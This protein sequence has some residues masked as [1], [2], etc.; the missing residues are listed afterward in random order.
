[1]TSSL[2]KEELEAM[3]NRFKKVCNMEV[4]RKELEE[5]FIND[6]LSKS[7]KSSN[8]TTSVQSILNFSELVAKL[9]EDIHIES[10]DK[11]KINKKLELMES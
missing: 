3:K 1:M 7:S 9:D 2:T 4:D 8:V 11:E 5:A 10:E 6:I